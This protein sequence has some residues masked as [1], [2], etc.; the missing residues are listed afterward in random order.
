MTTAR[1]TRPPSKRSVKTPSKSV[2]PPLDAVMHT[3]LTL[4]EVDDP[5][6]LEELRVDRRLGPCIVAQLSDRVAV[7]KPGSSEWFLRTLLKAGHTPK[8]LNP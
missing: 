2:A 1:R 6:L 4:V 8:V 5:L 7:V 3:N